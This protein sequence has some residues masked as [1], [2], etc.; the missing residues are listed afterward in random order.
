MGS[1]FSLID[2]D[3]LAQHV[4]RLPLR[5]LEGVPADDRAVATAVADG[6]HLGKDAVE[7]LGLAAREDDDPPAVKGRLHDMADARSRGRYIDV[8][9]LVDLLRRSKFEVRGRR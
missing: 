6:T 1:V 5:P 2:L 4:E 9:V 7:I 3:D 8:V